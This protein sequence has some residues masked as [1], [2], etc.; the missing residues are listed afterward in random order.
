[1]FGQQD[2]P[3]ARL[4]QLG[5]AMQPRGRLPQGRHEVQNRGGQGP[6]TGHRQGH[7]RLLERTSAGEPGVRICVHKKLHLEQVSHFLGVEGQ[8][9]FEE[10]HICGVDSNRLLLPAK[11]RA[12]DGPSQVGGA[13]EEETREAVW[14][15]GVLAP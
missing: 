2:I 5:W 6:V 3:G 7:L 1:M 12:D 13:R 11:H 9:P 8:D 15:S 10:H 4:T 14:E